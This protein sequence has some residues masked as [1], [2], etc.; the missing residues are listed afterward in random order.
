MCQNI[1]HYSLRE[2]IIWET[3]TEFFICEIVGKRQFGKP[4]RRWNDNIKT[5][6]K[7]G[8]DE[9]CSNL[10]YALMVECCE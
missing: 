10:E 3:R 1:F 7:V 5:D 2:Y 9:R 8:C 6:L 4:I